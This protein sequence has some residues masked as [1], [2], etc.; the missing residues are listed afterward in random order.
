M[1]LALFICLG[2]FIIS[3]IASADVGDRCG[4]E[5][6]T[7]G[8]SCCG[9]VVTSLIDCPGQTGGG[10]TENSG[11]WGILLL[12]INILTAG[13]AVAAIGGIVYGSVLYS[14]AG[15]DAANVKKAK[16]MIV[17]VVMGLVAYAFMYA[18]LNYLI[19]GG[20]L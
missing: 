7:V 5:T 2:G 19:P 15:G 13:I 1:A 4:S 17:N 14:T 8:Q 9:G 3:P 11:I 10:P 16:E 12:V 20:I 6:L 18:L